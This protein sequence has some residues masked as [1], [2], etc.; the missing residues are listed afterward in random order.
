MRGAHR[1]LP[2]RAAGRL[3]PMEAGASRAGSEGGDG[4]V[5]GRAPGRLPLAARLAAACGALALLGGCSD[6]GTVA[7]DR[8]PRPLITVSASTSM[9][10]ALTTCAANFEP[11]RLRLRF[12]TS[13]EL[14]ARLRKGERPDVFAA[15]DTAVPAA[16]ARQ[17]LIERPEG[18]VADALVIAVPKDHA[19]DVHAAADLAKPGVAVAVGAPAGELGVATRRVLRRLGA[20]DARVIL[21]NVRATAPDS[22]GVVARLL[23][24]AADAGFA[25][26]SDVEA[27]NG[28]LAAVQLPDTLQP[29]V[30]YAAGV[31]KGTAQP[32]IAQAFLDDLREGDCHDAL[33][34][35]GFD[36]PP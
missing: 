29:A 10:D 11:G 33:L 25:Y 7:P 2:T 34:T 3:T 30:P 6:A 19:G 9:R 28:G 17:G 23:Q 18:F 22:L 14:A 31:V 15:A 32:A 26:R 20:H 27:T 13:S 24:G 16:L 12:G 35:A 8:T 5:G 36:E 1:W 4:P 21:A